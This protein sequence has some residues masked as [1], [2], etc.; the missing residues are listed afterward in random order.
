[1]KMKEWRRNH[2]FYLVMRLIYFDQNADSWSESECRDG[3]EELLNS[4]VTDASGETKFGVY[5]IWSFLVM[6]GSI[7]I[8]SKQ[9]IDPY[10]EN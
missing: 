9:R 8:C 4:M 10:G 5:L 6:G 3:E 1:M 7:L 2:N